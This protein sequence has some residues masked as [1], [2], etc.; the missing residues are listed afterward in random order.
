MRPVL[1]DAMTPYR[2]KDGKEYIDIP[3]SWF[4]CC[5]CGGDGSVY[6]QRCEA[7]PPRYEHRWTISGV[8]K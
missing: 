1:R 3:E 6:G 7:I 4:R 8:R 5:Y 2:D